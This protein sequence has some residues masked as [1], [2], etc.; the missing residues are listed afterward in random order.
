MGTLSSLI[1]HRD[2]DE[3]QC[4]QLADWISTQMAQTKGNFAN[5]LMVIKSVVN[6]QVRM[7][8]LCAWEMICDR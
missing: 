6:D 8:M 3:Q 7:R 1:G 2:P 5:V 4:S